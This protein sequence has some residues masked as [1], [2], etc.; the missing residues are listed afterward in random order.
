MDSGPAGRRNLLL[1]S[2]LAASLVLFALACTISKSVAY[3]PLFASALLGLLLRLHTRDGFHFP[4][5]V[6]ILVGIWVAITLW[7]Y[8][9]IVVNKGSG[10]AAPFARAVDFLPVFI[11]AGLPLDI[12]WKKKAAAASFFV[13]ASATALIVLFG[14]YQ[15]ATGILYPLPVQ[16]YSDGKL[17]GFFSHHIPAGGFF[18]TLTVMSACLLLFWETSKKLK[19]FL[20]ILLLLLLSGSILSL[21]R[22]YF[23]SLFIILPL[24]FFKKNLRS[25]AIGI[26]LIALFIAVSITAL[27][28]VREGILSITDLKHN[29]SNMERLYLWRVAE[30]MI[31]TNPVVGIGYRQWGEKVSGYSAKY[32]SEWKFSDAMFHHAH[33]VY[34]HVTAETGLIGLSLFL[35]FWLSLTVLLFRAPAVGD[36]RGLIHAL[37]LGAAFSI[38]NL[39]I[40]GIFENNF[41]TLLISM[42]ISYVVLLALFVTSDADARA[43][44]SYLAGEDAQ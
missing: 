33:N 42:L 7:D 9:S 26:S 27:P 18:S 10:A 5:G 40:G 1:R 11:L 23:V 29:P 43:C 37:R 44:T 32:S 28:T 35:A 20:G 22:T 31:E 38:I 25:A 21:S 34:L 15:G 4:R 12:G 13:L 3:F 16:P 36:D 8:I 2:A 6:K 17:V 14:A 41:G 19:L 39:L 24:L 30:D